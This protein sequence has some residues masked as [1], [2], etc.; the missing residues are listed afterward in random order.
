MLGLKLIPV[1]KREPWSEVLFYIHA[2]VLLKKKFTQFHFRETIFCVLI[3]I[4]LKY[5]FGVL[6]DI[7]STLIEVMAWASL[8]NSLRPSDAYMRRWTNHH[9]FR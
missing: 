4:S 3:Q 9:W 2:W 5:I 6:I 1:S 8:I 7:Q